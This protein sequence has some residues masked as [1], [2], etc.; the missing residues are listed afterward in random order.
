M[1]PKSARLAPS[2]VARLLCLLLGAAA[3]LGGCYTPQALNIKDSEAM[4]YSARATWRLTPTP[5]G[6]LEVEVGQVRGSDVQ[7]LPDFNTVTLGGRSIT[8]P[9]TL[10]NEATLRHGHFVYNHL[11]FPNRPVEMEWFAGIAALRLDWTTTPTTPAQPAISHRLG[12]WGGT[13]GVAGRWKI[14]SN[15]AIEGRLSAMGTLLGTPEYEGTRG[16][17][18]LV[19]V[20]SPVPELRLRLGYA[21]SSTRMQGRDFRN[22]DSE[23]SFKTRGPIAGLTFEWR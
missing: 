10:Q 1:R 6:G 11:L 13:G 23:V 3:A 22:S 8:G 2:A 17:G 21:E 9:V 7:A 19:L 16:A 12:T 18:E 4:S 15:F 14:N 20:L 5:R